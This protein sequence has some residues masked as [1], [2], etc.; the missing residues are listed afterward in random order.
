MIVNGD[1]GHPPTRYFYICWKPTHISP[2]CPSISDEEREAIA[3]RREAALADMSRMVRFR[4]SPAWLKSD[5][6]PSLIRQGE[7][8]HVRFGECHNVGMDQKT[9]YGVR[10]TSQ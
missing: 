9:S 3:K 10:V 2:D 6:Q 7:E 8:P 1:S 4:P 5:K